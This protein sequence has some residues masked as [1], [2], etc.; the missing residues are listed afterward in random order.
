MTYSGSINWLKFLQVLAGACAALLLSSCG[1]SSV[2]SSSASPEASAANPVASAA[3]G[4]SLTGVL[5]G[6]QAPIVGSS[7]TLY[8]AGVPATAVPN[9]LGTSTTDA[10][11]SFNIPYVC[12]KVRTLVYVV[13]AGGNAGGGVNSAI[14]LM[15]ALGPCDSLPSSIVINELTT[16]A[17]V[18]ALNAFSNISSNSTGL[19]G[20]VDCVPVVQA[21][22]TQLHGNSPAINNAFETAALLVDVASGVP[23]HWLPPSASCT[24]TAATNPVN[25]SA[26]QKLTALGNSLAACVN[27]ATGSTQCQQLFECAVPHSSVSNAS[28]NTCTV[29]PGAIES[30]D[31]LQATLSIARNAGDVSSAGIE[32]LAARNIVFS[33]GSTN[34]LDLTIALNFTG[35]GLAYGQGIAIDATGNVW[36][37]NIIPSTTGNGSSVSELSP[38]GVPLSPSSGFTGGGLNVAAGIA[39]DALGNVWVANRTSEGGSGNSVTELNPSG[40]AVSPATGF[41]GGGLNDPFAIAIDAAG[42]VWIANNTASS[43]TELNPSGAPVSP[44]AGFVSNGVGNFSEIAIDAAGNIWGTT[45]GNTLVE[46]SANGSL[47]SP[48]GGFTFT[49]SAQFAGI[50]VDLYGNIWAANN[51]GANVVEFNPSGTPLSNAGFTGGGLSFPSAIAIDGAGNVWVQN[52]GISGISELDTL[53][54]PLSPGRVGFTGGGLDSA[55]G[56]AIDGAGDVW[57][58]NANGSVTEFIGAAAPTVTPLVAQIS[59]PLSALLSITVTPTSAAVTVGGTQQ[60]TATGTYADASVR[61]LS[62]S[63]TWS[64]SNTAFATIAAGGLATCVAPGAVDITASMTQDGTIITGTATQALTCSAPIV[65]SG[66]ACN[67]VPANPGGAQPYDNQSYCITFSGVTDISYQFTG[68]LT[69]TTPSTPGTVTGCSYWSSGTVSGAGPYSTAQTPCS[70]VINASAGTPTLNLLD[71]FGNSFSLSFINGAEV[72]GS[73]TFSVFGPTAAAGGNASGQITAT[74]PTAATAAARLHQQR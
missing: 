32:T 7:L 30:S 47:I 43:V 54:R 63:A 46:F 16:V 64:S 39:I 17:A 70:G 29:P 40:A 44:A 68:T 36:V 5:H 45:V 48:S 27:S 38:S 34:S 2:M 26:V 61:N 18:Y 12:P 25:C 71:A 3:N 14:K 56:I 41:T 6:G 50:A 35:G 55:P 53:G 21:D 22:M 69:F 13:A 20:C 74:S 23:A 1:S 8:A 60:F 65:S 58:P 72:S 62:T 33:P 52:N 73:Y 19:G 37:T 51:N 15:A 31:T 11:G 24:G 59:K 4:V 28:A 9:M 49:G 67:A 42:N 57:V 66:P 10:N